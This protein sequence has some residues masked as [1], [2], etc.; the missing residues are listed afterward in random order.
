MDRLKSVIQGSG[1]VAPRRKNLWCSIGEIRSSLDFPIVR[2][3]VQSPKWQAEVLLK[4]LIVDDNA[5]VRRLIRSIVLPFASEIYECTDGADS[6]S[7]YQAHRPDVVLMD[8]RMNDVD[9]IEATKHI[10]AADP[11]ARIVIV[12]DYD[13]DVLRQAAM[14]AGACGYALKDNLLDL[15][16]L[17]EAFG[18]V[19][20]PSDES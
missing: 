8:I 1:Y 10:K 5:T 12:T 20:R 14:R 19:L 11:K 6:F 16:R 4:L 13:D 15:V 3:K 17:L 7:T 2:L 9:G 18:Q